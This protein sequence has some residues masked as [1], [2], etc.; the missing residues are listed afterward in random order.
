MGAV[1]QLRSVSVMRP[2]PSHR[3]HVDF[4]RLMVAGTA[5]AEWKFNPR[6]ARGHENRARV[7][8]SFFADMPLT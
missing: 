1:S 7:V 3:R 6:L 5:S 4:H 8:I 2:T